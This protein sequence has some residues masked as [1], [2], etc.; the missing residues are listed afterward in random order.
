MR[1]DRCDTCKLPIKHATRVTGHCPWCGKA[2]EASPDTLDAAGSPEEVWVSD[3][4]GRR[5]S[6]W[7][8]GVGILGLAVFIGIGVWLDR[9]PP[10]EPMDIAQLESE[11]VATVDPE[12]EPQEPAKA[13]P[14]AI[15]PAPEEPPVIVVGPP[16]PP[17]PPGPVPEKA[18]IV[19]AEPTPPPAPAEPVPSRLPEA[20]PKPLAPP[21]PRQAVDDQTRRQLEQQI[22]STE[23]LRRHAV[24]RRKQTQR[25]YEQKHASLQRK[26]EQNQR[27][28]ENTLVQMRKRYATLPEDDREQKLRDYEEKVVE[29][30]VALQ[31]ANLKRNQDLQEKN[32]QRIEGQIENFDKKIDALKKQLF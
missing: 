4:L 10:D 5:K 27:K 14:E 20:E 23:R 31:A 11:P 28:F 19:E 13:S 30:N 7:I 2:L 6:R 8:L 18:P 26:Q 15:V 17:V 25:K 22:Q 12:V 24:E 32:M 29:R 21:E 3:A 16:S 1:I 9:H